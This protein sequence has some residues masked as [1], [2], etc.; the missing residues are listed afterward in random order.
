[1]KFSVFA[2]IVSMQIFH[3]DLIAQQIESGMQL[4]SERF[5][6]EKLHIHFDRSVYRNGET[7]FYKAYLFT[8]TE[9]SGISKTIYVD[10]YDENG[11]L[12]LQSQAP[13]LL[14]GA[15]G[16]FSIPEKYNGKSL[17]VK[18]YTRWMLNFDTAFLY[19]QSIKVYQ[20]DINPS[21]VTKQKTIVQ[22]QLYPEGGF[23]IAGIN[24][25]FAFKAID[26]WQKPVRIEAV[27]KNK[28]GILVDSVKSVHDG[29]G[30]FFLN[31]QNDEG[32]TFHWA[33]EK[34]HGGK[35][36]LTARKNPELF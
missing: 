10:W 3:S 31:L 35:I 6:P 23:S 15:K 14:S 16:S 27:I 29:M 25:R 18:A 13:V 26:Q 24:N 22:I 2:L 7:V 19:C 5:E 11:I 1:M 17:Q 9:V 32:Y 8:K 12:L 30:M 33:D 36:D 34:G 21:Y 28:K 4:L 20:P